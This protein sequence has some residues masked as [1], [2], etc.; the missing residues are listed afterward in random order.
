MKTKEKTNLPFAWIRSSFL[1][2]SIGMDIIRGNVMQDYV[3]DKTNSL[4]I[5]SDGDDPHFP[6]TDYTHTR[7]LDMVP[8]KR[9]EVK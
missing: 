6:G 9:P 5:D 8:R 7:P 1:S 4:E 3:V 2:S